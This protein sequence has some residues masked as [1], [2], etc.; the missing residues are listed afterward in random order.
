MVS[1]RAITSEFVSPGFTSEIVIDDI[2]SITN[3]DA[4]GIQGES[5]YKYDR[6]AI[7]N[8]GSIEIDT[9]TGNE[10]AYGINFVGTESE[11]TNG[12]TISN[13][14][15]LNGDAYG[16]KAEKHTTNDNNMITDLSVGDISQITNINATNGA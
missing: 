5:H 2:E 7:L 13:I 1:I 11:I 4:Y 6:P 10:N 9:V 3:K 14:T 15:A 12:L 16:L 8:S